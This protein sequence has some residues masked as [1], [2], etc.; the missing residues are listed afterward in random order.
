MSLKD[1]IYLLYI[2]LIP[3]LLGGFALSLASLEPYPA[4]VFPGF[5]QAGSADHSLYFEKP[6]FDFYSGGQVYELEAAEVLDQLPESYISAVLQ[7][8]YRY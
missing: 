2:L 7:N 5:E 1:R 6:V 3:V 4:M 8:R